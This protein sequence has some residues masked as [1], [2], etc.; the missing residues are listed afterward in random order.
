[1]DNKEF[2]AIENNE[3][4]ER[5][6][7]DFEKEINLNFIKK[8]LMI[9]LAYSEV[10][11]K[12]VLDTEVKNFIRKI[13]Y[14]AKERVNY[15][16]LMTN[17]EN[18]ESKTIRNRKRL[19]CIDATGNNQVDTYIDNNISIIKSVLEENENK[20]TL[21]VSVQGQIKKNNIHIDGST[22]TKSIVDQVM[23]NLQDNNQQFDLQK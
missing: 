12:A 20:A 7:N 15:T 2:K 10:V 4:K 3:L 21:E 1:M 18:G 23:I 11:E 8:D 22:I 5:V 9:T 17:L 6:L 14:K 13:N 19:R 16:I